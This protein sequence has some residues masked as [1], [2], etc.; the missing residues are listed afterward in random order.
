MPRRTELSNFQ[1]GEI[2]AFQADGKGYKCIAKQL[3]LSIG[4]IQTLVTKQRNYGLINQRERPRKLSKCEE[5][6]IV[7]SV[8]NELKSAKEEKKELHLNVSRDTILRKIKH[9]SKL[10]FAKIK[11]VPRL[12]PTHREALSG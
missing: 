11:P 3:K 6:K 12:K 4:A 2:T 8:S 9:N 10:V 7:R 5:R 1:K